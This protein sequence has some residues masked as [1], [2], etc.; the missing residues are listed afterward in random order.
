M[1]D[2]QCLLSS[3]QA[4]ATVIIVW[5]FNWGTPATL[6]A[7]QGPDVH[8]VLQRLGIPAA[9]L[10]GVQVDAIEVACQSAERGSNCD[11]N[12]STRSDQ[13]CRAV[14]VD[15]ALRLRLEQIRD[16][17]SAEVVTHVR[18]GSGVFA[19]F[20][21]SARRATMGHRDAQGNTGHREIPL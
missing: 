11:I 20:Q 10:D 4:M 13:T 6:V 3:R 5:S 2:R 17:G 7:Q 18:C 15:V 21:T 12:F 8:T 9:T 19:V 1:Y 16:G 14:A